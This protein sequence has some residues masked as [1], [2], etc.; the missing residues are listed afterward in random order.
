MT[1]S[2]DQGSVDL[3][4]K[5]LRRALSRNTVQAAVLDLDG[6]LYSSKVGLEFQIKPRMVGQ[7][8]IELGLSER[9]ARDLLR[10]YREAYGASVVGLKKHHEIDPEQFLT[11]VFS[12]LDVDGLTPY[13]GLIEELPRLAD[14]IPLYLLTNSSAS[15][16]AALLRLLGLEP[17][18]R[19][20]FSVSAAGYIRKPD[21]RAYETLLENTGIP[22]DRVLVFDDSWPNLH[23]AHKLKMWTVLVSNGVADPPQFWEMHRRE[24][25]TAPDWVDGYTH[26][27]GR[28]LGRINQALTG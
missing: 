15:H 23:A 21:P 10:R 19:K 13:D 24:F 26:D 8:Q 27:F 4:K 28:T 5:S 16:V 9:D 14:Q 25:H 17:C 3:I 6:T 12:G 11:S 22:P 2:V 1:S 20:A 7:A 18:F